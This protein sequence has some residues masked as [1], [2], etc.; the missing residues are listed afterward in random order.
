MKKGS[1]LLLLFLCTFIMLSGCSKETEAPPQT[2][3]AG[4]AEEALQI[5][6]AA[7]QDWDADTLQQYFTEDL[8]ASFH[9]D[10]IQQ[11][12]GQSQNQEVQTLLFGNMTYQILSC[13]EDGET[14]AASV[15]ITNKNMAQVMQAFVS[16]L[17]N[18]AFENSGQS[19][20]PAS[21][22]EQY[23]SLLRESIEDST[24]TDLTQ[25]VAVT[26]RRTDQQWKVETTDALA[27]ALAGG[28][29]SYAKGVDEAP[30]QLQTIRDWVSNTLWPD[31]QSVLTALET[32]GTPEQAA[33]DQLAQ[34]MAQK[35]DYDTYLSGLGDTYAGI[36]TAWENLSGEIDTLYAQILSADAGA[37]ALDISLYQQYF[38][39]FDEAVAALEG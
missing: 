30:A 39:A 12:G 17:M 37:A 6:L 11:D 25:T 7:V 28:L 15:E 38:A 13:T 2:T 31:M 16:K 1:W 32:G 8:A 5:A 34:A 29:L 27:D 24:V 36:L 3:E 22:D 21:P 23:V 9:L 33:L 26:L 35:T 18:A 20:E 19:E 14:A 4:T 10:G